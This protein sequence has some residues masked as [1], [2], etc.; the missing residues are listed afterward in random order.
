MPYTDFSLYEEWSKQE[1]A[2]KAELAI[3]RPVVFLPASWGK[4]FGAY[5]IDSVLLGIPLSMFAFGSMF[6]SLQGVQNSVDPATGELDQAAVQTV[7]TQ[8]FGSIL[9]LTIAF[10]IFGTLYYVLMHGFR[11][12]TVG[13]M[14]LGI[15]VV[16]EDGSPIGFGTAFKRALVFPIGGILPVVGSLLTLLNGLWPMWDPKKQS[17]ADKLAHTIVGEEQEPSMASLIRPPI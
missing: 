16:N 8:Y 12:Q 5:L 13:K 17:L 9:K 1:E 3:P 11:G 2:H 14:A 15:T 7:M 4:R 6:N 10:T